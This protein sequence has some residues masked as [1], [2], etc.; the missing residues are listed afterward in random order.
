MAIKLGSKVRDN[1]T[2]FEGIATGRTEW[3]FGCNRVCVEPTELK[4]GKPIEAQWFDEQRMEVVAEQAPVVSKDSSAT[5]GGPKMDP[6][7]LIG[8]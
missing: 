1:I 6:R 5:T 3:L 8:G 2:G 4:D 7:P